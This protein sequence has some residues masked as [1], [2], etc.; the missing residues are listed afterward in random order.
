MEIYNHHKIYN[1]TFFVYGHRG[2]PFLQK[3][4]TLRS[5]QKAIDLG[6]D[7]VELDI[8]ST[9]DGK[10]IVNHDTFL[11]IDSSE[12]EYPVSSVNY[13]KIKDLPILKDILISIGHMTKINIEVKDQGK[14]SFTAVKDLIKILKEL[15]LIDNVIISS[16]NPNI[17]KEAKK[18]DDRFPTAWIWEEEN[19]KFYNLYSIVL[20][21]YKPDA[22]HMYHRIVSKKLVQKIHKKGMKV[23]VYTVNNKEKLER[24][25]LK[26]IDGVFTDSPKIL[27][28]VNQKIHQNLL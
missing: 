21:Y 22:I 11:K 12:K 26:K 8:V 27:E 5:F 10:L 7:G 2:V 1:E 28:E 6:F 23:I 13:E 24:L 17:I 4:N 14:I 19:L 15:N 9:K 18:I 16:F 3:E 25:I 20:K